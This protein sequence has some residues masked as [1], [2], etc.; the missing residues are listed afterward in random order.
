MLFR[1]KDIAEHT[2]IPIW[3]NIQPYNSVESTQTA[4]V[5]AYLVPGA[6]S[7]VVIFPGGGYFQLSEISEGSSV[8]KAYNKLG[9]SAYVVSYRYRPN[10]GDAILADGKRALEL[11]SVYNAYAGINKTAYCGFSAGGHLAEVMCAYGKKPDACVLCYAVTTLS[12][13]TF[14]TMPKIFLGDKSEDNGERLK[15]SYQT[16]AEKMPPS[17]IWY[18]ERYTAV[19]YEKISRALYDALTHNGIKCEIHAYAD[20]GHGIWLGTDYP[21]CSGWLNSSA[22][23]LKKTGF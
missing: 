1:E 9:F 17:F 12:D 10:G 20:G 8:A 4:T 5:S 2:K 6:R 23:F 16:I 14:P 13:G 21:E 11:I 18:S 22:A 3:G 19:D 7:C 15:Y